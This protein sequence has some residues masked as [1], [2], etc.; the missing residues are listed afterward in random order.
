M[1]TV[2]CSCFA[3]WEVHISGVVMWISGL[4]FKAV[5][6][7]FL[8]SKS[9]R[10]FRFGPTLNMRPVDVLSALQCRGCKHVFTRSVHDANQTVLRWDALFSRSPFFFFFIKMTENVELLWMIVILVLFGFWQLDSTVFYSVSISAAVLISRNDSCLLQTSVSLYKKFSPHLAVSESDWG[11]TF[12]FSSYV[13]SLT[14]VKKVTCEV[15]LSCLVFLS[16]L[17]ISRLQ[18]MELWKEN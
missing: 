10:R 17:K 4:Q 15:W 18:T 16:K 7:S 5:F 14:P 11:F 13:L 6:I 3:D 9:I 2:A 12:F 1:N 8:Q